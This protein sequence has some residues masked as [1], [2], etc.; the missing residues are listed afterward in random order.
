MRTF[1]T[2]IGVFMWPE[3]KGLVKHPLKV[4]QEVNAEFRIRFCFQIYT[5]GNMIVAQHVE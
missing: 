3:I 4:L 5:D 1:M 2:L